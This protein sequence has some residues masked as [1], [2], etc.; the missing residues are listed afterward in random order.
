MKERCQNLKEI[1]LTVDSISEEGFHPLSYRYLI[2]SSHYRNTLNFSYDA[3]SSAQNAYKGLYEKIQEWQAEVSERKN[4]IRDPELVQK[5]SDE[6]W[7]AMANDLHTPTAMA[8]AWAVVKDEKLSSQDKL[9]LFSEFDAVF[10]LRTI[11]SSSRFIF[12]R[13]RNY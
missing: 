11:R 3:L 1:F 13:K 2:L 5:Y 7:D 9:S 8:V 12:R 4:Q 6:F 10:G